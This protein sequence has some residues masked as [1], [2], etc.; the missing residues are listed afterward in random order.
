[1]S[2][3][4]VSALLAVTL[5]FALPGLAHGQQNPLDPEKGLWNRPDYDAIYNA[6]RIDE[7]TAR[8]L[9]AEYRAAVDALAAK[10]YA[11]AEQMLADLI[12]R[13]PAKRDTTFLMGLSKIGLGKWDEAKAFLELAVVAEP[14]RPE[15][16][17]RLG[18]AYLQLNEF[19]KARQQRDA[20]AGLDSKCAR[21]CADA[22]WI[23]EGLTMLDERINAPALLRTSDTAV[24][25][26]ASG[27][28][29]DFR[30]IDPSKYSIVTFS[31]EHD[32]YDLLTKDGRCPPKKLAEPRQPC[33][34]ILY[35]PLGSDGAGLSA[36]FKPV[37]GVV[38]RKAIWAIHN[39]K[40]QKVEIEDLYFDNDD[41]IGATRAVY[42]ST[43]VIG[44]TENAANCGKGLPCLSNLV[45]Q[46]MFRMYSN[47]PD[48]VVNVIWGQGMKD[49][50]TVR[51]R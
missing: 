26:G 20:L 25:W 35:T 7:D 28:S 13:A 3:R 4:V 48:S 32:L 14:A 6:D 46:N 38:S 37:F 11:G 19:D 24:P 10:D 30:E 1:M 40:L 22:K 31:D 39:K 34:L 49:V 18:L 21:I 15:A 29:S 23:S 5:S 12:P 43:G 27:G 17:T 50:G 41:I 51:I 47:M 42:R 2:S 36:N 33:A 16:K 9:D 45:A 44:N 8:A